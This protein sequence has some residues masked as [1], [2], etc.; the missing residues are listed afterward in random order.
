MENSTLRQTNPNA[1][2][3]PLNHQTEES[4]IAQVSIDVRETVPP[5]TTSKLL[6]HVEALRLQQQMVGNFI[7]RTLMKSIRINPDT[8][9]F[10][11]VLTHLDKPEFI[12]EIAQ[13]VEVEPGRLSVNI[14]LCYGNFFQGIF[15]D[16]HLLRSKAAKKT[17][18]AI[19]WTEL[20]QAMIDEEEYPGLVLEH[21]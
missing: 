10:D 12:E 17:L 4:G 1:E 14:T 3:D 9:S 16:G 7:G 2:R 21:L 8:W 15:V 6:A 13:L 5:T 19:P 11:L 18:Q 20:V